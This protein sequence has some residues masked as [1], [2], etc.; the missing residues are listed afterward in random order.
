MTRV[1]A[2][3]SGKGGVGKTTLASNLSAALAKL[4]KDV[5]AIDTNL[6]TPNL[7]LQLGLHLTSNNLHKLLKGEVD[8][9]SSIYYHPS[10]FKLIPASMNINDLSDVDVGRLPEITLNLIGKTDY[11]ILDCAAGLGREALNALYASTEILL[12]TNPELPSVMDALRTAKIAKS[13]NKEILGVVVNRVRGKWYELSKERIEEI[14][15]LPVLAEIPEDVNVQK[16]VSIKMPA[17]E[18]A[19]LSPAS[20]EIRKLAHRLCGLPF[21]FKPQARPNLI[22]RLVEWMTK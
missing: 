11:V 21:D 6:T 4:N 20:I 18:F 19:P 7:G 1:I 13:V 10:G 8:I 17:V 2:I 9:K 12:V 15:E 16:S 14:L 3:I 5:V 22:Q